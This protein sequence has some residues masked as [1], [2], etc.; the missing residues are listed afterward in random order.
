MPNAAPACLIWNDYVNISQEDEIMSHASDYKPLFNVMEYDKNEIHKTLS[1][2][3]LTKIFHS[4]NKIFCY[5]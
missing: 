2:I 3:F 5:C 1:F 4:P